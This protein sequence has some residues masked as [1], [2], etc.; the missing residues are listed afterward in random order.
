MFVPDEFCR[1]SSRL[2]GECVVPLCAGL[3]GNK[4]WVIVVLEVRAGVVS[5]NSASQSGK[6]ISRNAWNPIR[7]NDLFFGS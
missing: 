4:P 2:L 3:V 1:I 6:D 5:A 7:N